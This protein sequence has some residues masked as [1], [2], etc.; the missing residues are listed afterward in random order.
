MK[1]STF[2]R[3]EILKQVQDDRDA[4]HAEFISASDATSNEIL[5]V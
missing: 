5:Y 3:I 2:K 1:Y 4:R